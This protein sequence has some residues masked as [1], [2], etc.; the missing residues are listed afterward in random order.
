MVSNQAIQETDDSE[1]N[2]RIILNQ[3]SDIKGENLY[4]SADAMAD[5]C[6]SNIESCDLL[7]Q[8]ESETESINNENIGVPEINVD[9]MVSLIVQDMSEFSLGTIS[10]SETSVNIDNQ[11]SNIQLWI[12]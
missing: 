12:D 8:R 10:E 6:V 3:T 2:D 4:N 7:T 1:L 5:K 11:N 9:N